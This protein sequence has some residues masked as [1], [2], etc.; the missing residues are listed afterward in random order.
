M[1]AVGGWRPECWDFLVIVQTH[2]FDL[3]GFGFSSFLLNRIRF[4]SCLLN[5]IWFIFGDS[6]SVYPVPVRLLAIL[7]LAEARKHSAFQQIRA[8]FGQPRGTLVNPRK[9]IDS[10]SFAQ[11]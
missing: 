5:R 4:V 1:E 10:R 3:S 9:H 2:V 6:G 7:I 11:A 8:H